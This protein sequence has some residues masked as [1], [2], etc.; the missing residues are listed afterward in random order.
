MPITLVGWCQSQ[1]TGGVL[2]LF[3]ALSDPHVRVEGTN[4]IVPAGM[5]QLLGAYAGGASIT[6]ARLASPSLARIVNQDLSPLNVG[7]EPTVPTPYLDM[8]ENPIALE[9][10][11]ALRAYAAGSESA[12]EYKTILAWLGSGPVTPYRG[13]Y[14]TVRATSS[15]T[16]SAYAWTNGTITFDQ[17]LPAGRYQ[18]VGM[19]A[20]SN[21]LIAARLVIPGFAW[22]P[23]V[24][25][26]DAVGD[27]E[28]L[29]FRYGNMGIL[30]E[31]THDSP[32]SVDFLSVSADTSEVVFLDLVKV[33]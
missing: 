1:N 17:T 8:F 4:V 27:V 3:N 18:V 20:V 16:L 6:L 30:G 2:T 24:V 9:A 13:T 19:R 33:A 15:T 7:A 22:R 29:R 12:A 10:T 26:F 28:P 23:G 25:G 21:G 31:F 11:E 5:N 32:P 14:R